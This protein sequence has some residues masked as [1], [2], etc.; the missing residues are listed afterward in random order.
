ML[1]LKIRRILYAILTI[2]KWWIRMRNCIGRETLTKLTIEAS[3]SREFSLLPIRELLML[4]REVSGG[5]SFL[6]ISW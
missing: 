5:S 6:G 2:E 3:D 4:V 1:K